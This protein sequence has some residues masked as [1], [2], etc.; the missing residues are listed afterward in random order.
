MKTPSKNFLTNAVQAAFFLTFLECVARESSALFLF[1]LFL[2]KIFENRF[3][4]ILQILHQ[5]SSGFSPFYNPLQNSTKFYKRRRQTRKT[6]TFLQKVTN[7]TKFI[8]CRR[9]KVFVF[10]YLYFCGFCRSCSGGIYVCYTEK[11]FFD[12]SLGVPFQ[13]GLF[14][15]SVLAVLPRCRLVSHLQCYRTAWTAL[16]PYYP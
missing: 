4:Q 2:R 3:L 10:N 12:V 9:Y 11:I 7:S 6:P 1:P 15:G 16:L 5:Y 13:V 14:R 8:I